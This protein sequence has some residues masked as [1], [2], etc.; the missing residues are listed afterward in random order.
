M[1]VP[2]HSLTVSRQPPF[3]VGG[4]DRLRLNL[5]RAMIGQTVD[6]QTDAHSIAHGIVAGVITE[7]GMPKLVVGRKVYALSQI[8]TAVPT[9]FN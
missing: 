1:F 9:H 7:A 4:C 3:P 5:A 8:L 6:L 2:H